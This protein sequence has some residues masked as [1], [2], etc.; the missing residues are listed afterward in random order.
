MP[1]HRA[2]RAS[3]RT[4]DAATPQITITRRKVV[5]KNEQGEEEAFLGMPLSRFRTA[6]C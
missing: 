3:L 5:V 2:S 4:F 6:R 1:G